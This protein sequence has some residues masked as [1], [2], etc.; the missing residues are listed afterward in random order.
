EPRQ[1]AP[2]MVDVRGRFT[3]YF[4]GGSAPKR[5]SELKAEEEARKAEEAQ[6]GATDD[7]AA[8]QAAADAKE[9]N[10]DEIGPKPAPAT[11]AEAAQAAPPPEPR[12]RERG[13]RAGRI[14]V[15]GDSDFVRDD[16]VRG[17]YQQAGGPVSGT[18][19]A[20]FFSYLL[21]WLAED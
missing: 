6:A 14:V 21:D 20:P 3:S 13:E 18:S 1:Q 19:G 11:D 12:M 10:P 15:I 16:L 2:L 9:A 7:A 4:A 8:K 5:P 17:E